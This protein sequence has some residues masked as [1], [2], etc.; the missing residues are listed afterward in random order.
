MVTG[1]MSSPY[2][3]LR[4]EDE[5]L[6]YDAGRMDMRDDILKDLR[7]LRAYYA[8]HDLWERATTIDLIMNKITTPY[9]EDEKPNE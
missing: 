2:T 9:A 3:R 1:L 7:K 6:M 5:E 4:T 8:N